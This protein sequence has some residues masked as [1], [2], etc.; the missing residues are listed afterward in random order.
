MKMERVKLIWIIAGALLFN[1]VFWNEK[2][3]INTFLYDVFLL[4]VLFYTYPNA[5]HSSTVRWLLAGH[6]IC[7]A[8]VLVHNTSLS[9]FAACST[10]LL[11]AAFAQYLHRSVLFATGSIVQNILFVVPSVFEAFDFKTKP[12][13]SKRSFSKWIR[14]AVIPVFFVLIFF[15]IYSFANT[16]FERA[17]VD[18][19]SSFEKFFTRFFDLFS[20]NRF[21][22]FVLGLII[23]GIIILRSKLNFFAKREEKHNDL[24]VRK[25]KNTTLS[26]P[27][28]FQEIARGILGRFSYGMMALKN[29]NTVG[30]LSLLLL[31]VLLLFVNVTDVVYIWSDFKPMDV[32]LYAVVHEGAGLLIVSILLAML[33]L[34]IVFHGNLNFYKRNTW[35]KRL[36][37]AWIFQNL[38]LVFSVFLRDYHYIKTAGLG[39]NRIGI[40]FYLAL[41]VAGLLSVAW[42]IHRHKTVYYLLRVNAW[43]AIVLMIGATTVNWD[44]FIVNYN[45][46]RKNE[47]VM[48]VVYMVSLSDS[49]LPVLDENREE[50]KR[51]EALMKKNGFWDYGVCDGCWE[52][53]LN[54]RIDL[55]K[56]EQRNYSW[57]SWNM[58]D[59]AAK[60]HFNISSIKPN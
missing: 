30:I 29:I 53:S 17:V 7:L 49:V 43:A 8:M 12:N 47:I 23:T 39:R 46:S 56:S 52:K 40:L 28:L 9:K 57:L 59:V 36:A 3:G 31:N 26:A 35:L 18:I 1:A 45:L 51:H 21:L 14:F 20:W 22:F 11:L 60:K 54:A 42:K 50:L 6:L 24:L 25:R 4:A 48:P 16:A 37:Y 55:Y 5:R 32:S 41:V 58:R 27:G 15:L 38:V 13:S 2:L 10:L 33:V 44:R 19:F 34:L